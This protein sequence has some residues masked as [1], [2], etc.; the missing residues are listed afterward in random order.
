[1][2][3]RI[4]TYCGQIIPRYM[5]NKFISYFRRRICS[6]EYLSM[7]K[8]NCKKYNKPHGPEVDPIRDTLMF[9]YIGGF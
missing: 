7:Q 8:G 5:P 6:F 4:G 1:M 3:T 9:L 2:I